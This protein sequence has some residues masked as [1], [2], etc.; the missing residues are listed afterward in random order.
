MPPELNFDVHWR[1]P[2]GCGWS[3]FFTE[4]AL[5]F[6]PGLRERDVNVKLLSGECDDSFLSGLEAADAAT[7]RATWVAESTLTQAQTA[8]SLAIEHGEPCGIRQYSSRTAAGRPWR[9]IARAMS[10]AD[11][12]AD[13]AQCLRSGADEVWVPT[14]WHVERFVAAGVP[15]S[16]LRVI[17][18]PVD[19]TF[20]A[21]QPLAASAAK[22][23]A[24]PFT[25]FS[26]FKWE[27]RK[28]WDLLL[29]AYWSTFA[30]GASSA[31][32]EDSGPKTKVLL[33][34][35]TYL[36]SW[37][38]G[39]PLQEQ[40]RLFARRHFGRELSTLPPVRLVEDD[41][42]RRCE[43]LSP[44]RKPFSRAKAFLPC[45]SLSP[46]RLSLSTNLCWL[47]RLPCALRVPFSASVAVDNQRDPPHLAGTLPTHLAAPSASPSPP[48]SPPPPPTPP[49]PPPFPGGCVISTRRPTPSYC[50]RAARGGASPSPR[51]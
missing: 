46:R 7:Y 13:K 49:S 11:L 27:L 28:G 32:V 30:E 36:P 1:V 12:G 24:R 50:P 26:N 15:R 51:P 48:P 47:P 33:V 18:E 19:T 37:E 20:F 17:P 41:V 9:V 16:R 6:I 31:T 34:I 42:S 29:L 39:P 43:S 25:F 40:L 21:P 23:S 35:K 14:Q 22:R 44:V 2:V 45:E 8:A 3:G 10:E 38:P 4:V 5:G